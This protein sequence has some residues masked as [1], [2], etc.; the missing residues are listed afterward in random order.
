MCAVQHQHLAPPLLCAALVS[1]RALQAHTMQASGKPP[2]KLP[3]TQQQIAAFAGLQIAKELLLLSG[4]RHSQPWAPRQQRLGNAKPMHCGR[5]LLLAE[6]PPL[7][8]RC[9]WRPAAQ[10]G[11]SFAAHLI[12]MLAHQSTALPAAR[13]GLAP[14]QCTSLWARLLLHS[15]RS[16][17]AGP[18]QMP[19]PVASAARRRS[20][21]PAPA[22]LLGAAPQRRRS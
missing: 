1:C 16:C 11:D 13:H 22:L 17:G 18:C 3:S 5:Q 15:K 21:C 2:T 9:T 7:A 4:S 6:Q 20:L 12:R 10:H 19:P 14:L 8:H